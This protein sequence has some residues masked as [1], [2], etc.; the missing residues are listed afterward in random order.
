MSK[1]C[2]ILG[3]GSLGR[4]WAASLAPGVANF[5]PRPESMLSGQCEYLLQTFQGSSVTVSV[6]WQPLPAPYTPS[7]LLVTTKAMHALPALTRIA[8]SLPDATPIVLFQNG[9]GSQQAVASM[10]PERPILAAT[11]TEA[12]NRPQPDVVVHAGRG[13]TWIGG[14][15]ATG[16]QALTPVVE[17]L[18]RSHL[19][20]RA[21]T[22]ITS[23]L[24]QKL[25]INAG[26]N[27]FTALLDCPNGQLRDQTFFLRHIDAVCEELAQLMNHEGIPADA[28]NLRV[29]IETVAQA[30][31]SN[32][33]SMRADVQMGR[34]TEI[35][36]INGYVARQ[37]AALNLP[38]PVN[39]MLTERV[40]SITNTQ[41]RG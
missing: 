9:M 28:K 3:A 16:K 37:S 32:T 38:A 10:F 29:D 5:V 18:S 1:G 23:G 12:A 40:H 22:D 30:T 36:F 31:A 24:W 8:A 17:L 14:L 19:Q 39:R 33:S 7:A 41:Q 21:A 2:L 34:P 25:V 26:I 27:P 35:D 11:T 20:I 13:V 4:F 15:N 6:P